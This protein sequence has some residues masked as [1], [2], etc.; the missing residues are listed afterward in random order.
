M[1]LFYDIYIPNNED[2]QLLTMHFSY[3]DNTDFIECLKKGDENAYTYL[4]S[5]YHKKLFVYI[6]SLNNDEAV[7]KDI[8]QN[9]FLKTWEYRK[10]LNPGYS[11]KSFLYKTA[12]NEFINQ[13]HKTRAISAL[14]RT[15]IEAIDE[16]VSEDNAEL[17]NRKIAFVNEGINHLPSKCKET[18]LLSKKEGLTNIEIAEYMNVSIKTVETQLTKSYKFLRKRVGTQLKGLFFLLFGIYKKRSV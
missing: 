4:V 16:T 17:L 18:F 15:Y 6:L 5:A 8:V 7:A 11:I 12:Y 13:Y 14:E 9:V 1:L 2:L 10:R 3:I